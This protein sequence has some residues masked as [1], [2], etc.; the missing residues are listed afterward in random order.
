MPSPMVISAY[1]SY[2]TAWFGRADHSI[3]FHLMWYSSWFSCLTHWTLSRFSGSFAGFSSFNP[4]LI[5]DYSLTWFGALYSPHVMP[6]NPIALS[7][8]YMLMYITCVCPPPHTLPGHGLSSKVRATIL[9]TSLMGGH[10][11]FNI[12]KTE[13]K[14]YLLYQFSPS[15]LF[16]N[17]RLQ[18]MKPKS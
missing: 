13:L 9:F 14:L 1:L 18:V 6:S 3:L 17:K 11:K 16:L 7:G 10:L 15:L 4:F 8:T 5:F 12:F 2:L